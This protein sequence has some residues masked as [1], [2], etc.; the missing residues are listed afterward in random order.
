M[1]S[2]VQGAD[3][4]RLALRHPEG[5]VDVALVRRQ[6]NDR[7]VD[8]DVDEAVVVVG[9]LDDGQVTLEGLLAVGAL[10]REE[11]EVAALAGDHH[12]L[13]RLGRHLLRANEGD[14]LHHHLGVLVDDEHHV[15]VG[16]ALDGVEPVGDLRQEVALLDVLL[17]DLLHRGAHGVHVQ[18]GGGLHVDLFL[19]I[20][21]AQLVVAAQ[22]HRAH[23]GALLHPHHVGNALGQPL[24]QKLNVRE[25]AQAPDGPEIVGRAERIVD[26]ALLRHEDAAHGLGLDAAVALDA[27]LDDAVAQLLDG[28]GVL[29]HR[30]VRGGRGGIRG[31]SLPGGWRGGHTRLGLCERTARNERPQGQREQRQERLQ[32]QNGR[33]QGAVGLKRAG[34]SKG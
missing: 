21:V 7:L 13:E 15:D 28:G 26:R 17:L 5:D 24:H 2:E 25:V 16:A 23:S 20:V 11:G 29:V 22:L 14:L 31:L 8:A 12:R 18:D 9:G 4:V 27:D 19:Q 32:R 3:V 33:P 34:Q 30:S 6:G 1:R 10:A